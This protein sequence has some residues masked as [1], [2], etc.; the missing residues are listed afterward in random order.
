MVLDER[1]SVLPQR[2]QAPDHAAQLIH[3]GA[4]EDTVNGHIQ[5]NLHLEAKTTVQLR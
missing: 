2:S 1:F 4:D 3:S 5:N